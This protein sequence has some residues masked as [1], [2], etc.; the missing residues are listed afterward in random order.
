MSKAYKAK[1]QEMFKMSLKLDRL[2]HAAG[3]HGT[4]G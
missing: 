2:M 4:P 3:G 1:A